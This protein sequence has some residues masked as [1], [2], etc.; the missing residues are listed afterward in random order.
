MGGGAVV[1]A[2]GRDVGSGPEEGDADDGFVGHGGLPAL[3]VVVDHLAV[4]GGED[5]V[6]VVGEAVAPEG[7]EDAADHVVDEGDHAVV[8][9]ADLAT[10]VVRLFT[11]DA[12]AVPGVFAVDGPA[13]VGRFEVEVV[14]GRD[15]EG[16]VGG[17]VHVAVG[18]G[19]AEGAVGVGE[20][21]PG[22]E[23]LGVVGLGAGVEPVDEL[24]GEVVGVVVFLGNGVVPGAGADRGLREASGSQRGMLSGCS[25]SSQTRQWPP[26]LRWP[27]KWVTWSKP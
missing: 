1:D 25:R 21:E 7:L 9:G 8:E 2:V 14:V 16:H 3:A 19:R 15:G 17:V 24:V 26:G 10:V 13:V 4:V 6:G 20:G 27:V 5:D 11:G 23:G 18:G 12:A 22:E